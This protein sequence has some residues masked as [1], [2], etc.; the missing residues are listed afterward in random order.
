M[1]ALLRDW[2]AAHVYV[3]L[4]LRVVVLALCSLMTLLALS[5]TLYSLWWLLRLLRPANVAK[6]ITK[7]IPGVRMGRLA[8]QEVEFAEIAGAEADAIRAMAHTIDEFSFRLAAAERALEEL[9][10]A[11]DHAGQ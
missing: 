8:E 11:I 3:D 4:A 6:F 1:G 2:V 10:E 5:A 9:A 7:E